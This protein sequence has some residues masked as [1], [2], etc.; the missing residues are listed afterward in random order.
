LLAL[1]LGLV[2]IGLQAVYSSTFGLAVTEYGD[3]N[4]FLVRQ[5]MWAAV[6]TAALVVCMNIPYRF[7]RAVSPLLMVVALVMLAL[8]LL[9]SFGINQY[10][11]QRWLRLGPLPPVQP[12]EFVKLA[13]IIYLA[14]WLSGENK[15]P[16]SVS[17]GFVPFL[18][19]LGVVAGLVMMEPD[20]GT[21]III[22]SVMITMFFLG[23]ASI[24]HII[25]LGVL[26]LSMVVALIASA[27]YRADRWYSFVDP[28]D[29]PSG[30]GFH[31]IQLLIALGSGGPWGLG[32][33]ASR[34]KFFYVPGAH[35]DGIFAIVGEEV[36]FIGGLMVIALLVALVYKGVT[37][38]IK[39][40][41][42]FGSLLAAGIVCWIA[43]QSIINLGGITRS[44]PLTGIP[45]PFISYGGSSL[46]ATM[47]AVGILLNISK[48]ASQP[49]RS[50]GSR[51]AKP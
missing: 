14:A 38:V 12:S 43:Y 21:T 7:W 22:A 48:S 5:S 47:A 34:Q 44:I 20:L 6:G 41:D 35:T 42:R 13:V 27:E 2:V 25:I 49:G 9:P 24:K 46:A 19:F 23:G 8:V 28:W 26:G 50:S 17:A 32:L 39:T 4:Y 30:R 45:L 1:V 33:G 11:A 15:R 37:I 3:V 29:D 18:I 51:E 40:P 10:G 31:V 36:G 16:D